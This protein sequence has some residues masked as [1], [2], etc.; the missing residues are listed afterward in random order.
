[1]FELVFNDLYDN[2]RKFRFPDDLLKGCVS[3]V[4]ATKITILLTLFNAP[5]VRSRGLAIAG[6]VPMGTEE[7]AGVVGGRG[8]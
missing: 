3:T 6:G 1:M 7:C 5:S 2:V 8:A 4:K